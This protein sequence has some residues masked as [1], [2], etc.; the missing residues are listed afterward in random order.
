MTAPPAAAR[1]S[2]PLAADRRRRA[3]AVRR[4]R[5]R[6]PHEGVAP[7]AA[8]RPRAG[9]RSRDARRQPGGRQRRR[10]RSR[11]RPGA[12]AGRGRG[13][14]GRP[15]RPGRRG[16]RRARGRGRRRLGG[17]RRAASPCERDRV[18]WVVPGGTLNHFARDLGLSD[19]AMT[20][21]RASRPGGSPPS[22]SATPTAS[23]SSTTPR[24][25]ST[26]TW[27]AGARPGA[28]AAQAARAA[29]RGRPTCARP[30]RSTWRSTASR[31][32]VYLVFVGNNSYTGDRAHRRASRS[33]AG[34]LDV[35]VL[36]AAGR[37]PRLTALW[38]I[39]TSPHGGSRWLT[40]S[41][42]SPRRG[43]P[44]GAGASWP[45]TARCSER[46]GEVVFSTARR[47]LRVVAPDPGV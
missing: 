47:A 10:R 41:L 29:G 43:A 22:T 5:R 39:L 9:P 4:R 7:A 40:Q 6:G 11:R 1:A 44:A 42:R 2:P 30:T 45:T 36:S 18:L 19:A 26:A 37:L 12:R 27:C 46:P 33:R 24:S 16:R 3:C 17:L 34:L 14:R 25:A 20:P 32:R 21:W 31:D 38:A 15:A 8:S 23:P 28:P 13:P 35:R